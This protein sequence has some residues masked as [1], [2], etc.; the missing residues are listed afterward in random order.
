M[1]E[2]CFIWF[3]FDILCFLSEGFTID[4]KRQCHAM[5]QQ[6][7]TEEHDSRSSSAAGE[8]NLQG[9]TAFVAKLL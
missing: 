1:L 9:L 7:R 8:L 3:V 4:H 5:F 6:G 2:V